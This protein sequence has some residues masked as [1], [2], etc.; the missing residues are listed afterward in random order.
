MPIARPLL[1]LAAGALLAGCSANDTA[2]NTSLVAGKEQFVK[3]C[4]SC[5]T[6]AR[7]GT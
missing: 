1:L 7:A 5:H 4:G 6:L 2:S 3:K